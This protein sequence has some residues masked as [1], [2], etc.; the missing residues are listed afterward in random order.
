LFLAVFSQN[1][2]HPIERDLYLKDLEAAR[3]KDEAVGEPR[4][5]SPS[6]VFI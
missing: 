2:G 5:P 4:H 6:E 3:W 1:R